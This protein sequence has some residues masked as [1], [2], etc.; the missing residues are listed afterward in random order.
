[1]SATSSSRKQLDEAKKTKPYFSKKEE[2]K[3]GFPPLHPFIFCYAQFRVEVEVEEIPNHKHQ[4]PN[5]F[6]I[7]NSKHSFDKLLSY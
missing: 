3:G 7:P 6:K 1:V 2:A 5:K 4:N